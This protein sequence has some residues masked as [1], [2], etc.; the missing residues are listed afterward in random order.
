MRVLRLQGQKLTWNMDRVG[1]GELAYLSRGSQTAVR[2]IQLQ[3]LNWQSQAW[4]TGRVGRPWGPQIWERGGVYTLLQFFS[5]HISANHRQ[6]PGR[7]GR[8]WA[9]LHEVYQGKGRRC[10]ARG[11]KLCLDLSSPP[12]VPPL[13][14]EVLTYGMGGG[15][16]NYFL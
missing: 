7:L 3:Q 13:W 16:T 6:S 15:S 9:R 2:R 4:A 14:N 5:L 12:P 10:C 11:T 1:T 8:L